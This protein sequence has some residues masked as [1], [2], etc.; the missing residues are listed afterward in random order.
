[1]SA[2]EGGSR[3]CASALRELSDAFLD[4]ASHAPTLIAADELEERA[5][6]LRYTARLVASG[7]IDLEV[8]E[9]F[10]TAAQTQIEALN[11]ESEPTA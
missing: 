11:I 8:A 2:S 9:S 4:H 6:T 10:I 1:M 3:E 5:A 7:S